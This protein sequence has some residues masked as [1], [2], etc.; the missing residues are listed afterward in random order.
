MSKMITFNTTKFKVAPL[1]VVIGIACSN[2]KLE[3]IK[4]IDSMATYKVKTPKS[5][6]L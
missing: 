3:T 4:S 6:S 2:F 5:S 1:L